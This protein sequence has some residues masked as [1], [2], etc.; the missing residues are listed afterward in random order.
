MTRKLGTINGP[1]LAMRSRQTIVGSNTLISS[2]SNGLVD[3][4]HPSR[5]HPQPLKGV[6]PVLITPFFPDKKESLD[7]GSFRKCV[8]FMKNEVRCQGVTI[9]GVLGEANRLTDFET[10]QL[11]RTA[12][13]AKRQQ[14]PNDDRD[15]CICVGVSHPGRAAT[16]DLCH[17]VTQLGADAVMVSPSKDSLSSPHPSDDAIFAMFESIAEACPGTTIVLQDLPSVSGVHMS[18]DLMARMVAEVP[19]LTTIKLESTPTIS[20]IAEFHAVSATDRESYSI[21]TGLGALFA[22]FDICGG[23]KQPESIQDGMLPRPTDGFM[24]GFAFPEVLIT[25][26]ELVLQDQYEKAKEVYEFFLPLIVL[27]SQ[28][29]EGLA[30]RKDIY[31]QRGL[32]SSSHVR[33][34][35]KCLSRT[36]RKTTEEQLSRLFTSR[37]IGIDRAWN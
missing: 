32:T 16:V 5:R 10:Q 35:G 37:S 28:P 18:I 15:F 19:Q 9:A 2:F 29:G 17:M 7:L 11:I 20:R 4:T 30:L 21:L 8:S 33:R 24:T 27:E 34:P 22:G 13:E 3:A 36:L 14:S 23:T 26:V 12:V 25:M 6:F 1:T 31:R